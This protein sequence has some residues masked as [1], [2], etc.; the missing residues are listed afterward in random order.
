MEA[1][2]L[3]PRAGSKKYDYSQGRARPD[4]GVQSGGTEAKVV[5]ISGTVIFGT[6]TRPLDGRKLFWLLP[7]GCRAAIRFALADVRRSDV[8]VGVPWEKFKQI[9]RSQKEQFEGCNQ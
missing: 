3:M 5:L 2:R 9:S 6:I 7:W 1:V 4:A 8:A